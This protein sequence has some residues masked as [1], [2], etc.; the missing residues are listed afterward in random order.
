MNVSNKLDLSVTPIFQ[1]NWAAI[2]ARENGERKYRYIINTGSSRSSK[3][4]SLI[5]CYDVYARTQKNK[6]LTVWRDTKTDCKKTVMND[7][8]KHFKSTNRYVD[9]RFNKTESIF[10]Y[11]TGS[12]FEIHGTDDETTV[13]GLNQDAAWLNEPYK[14]SKAIFDQI[15]QRT[16]DFIIIDWN[17]RMAHWIE[18]LSKDKRAIVIHSTVFDNPF[19]PPEQLIKILSYQPVKMCSV[20]IDKLLTEKEANEYDVVI[21]SLQLTEKQIIELSRCKENEHKK[22]ASEYNWSVYGLGLKAERPNRIF[23]WEEISPAEYQQLD[24]PIY[25]YSDWGAQDPWAIGEV[26]YYDGGLYLKEHNYESENTLRAR[27]TPTELQQIGLVDEGIVSWMFN[28]LGIDI[29][30]PVVCDPNR[31]MKIRALRSVGYDYAIAAQKPPGSIIDGIDLLNNLRVYYTSDS[32]NIKYEQENYSREVDRYGIVLE[33]P[34][35]TD[36]HHMDGVRYVGSFLQQQ[37]II[38]KI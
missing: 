18:D 29:S 15:D 23:H 34:E 6:R 9:S 13:H 12:T 16:E 7:A 36:N 31:I 11:Q 38:R 5:D 24:V 35:D 33:E 32:P 10:N 30:R 17:P 19:C 8:L 2:T 28:K 20:V 27:L 4:F 21:N 25:Y 26:K 1:R 22:S 37:G 3:T 14:I